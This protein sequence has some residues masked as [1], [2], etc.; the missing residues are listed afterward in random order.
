MAQMLRDTDST[1]RHLNM[2]RRH[3]R[4]CGYV[5]GTEQLITNLKSGVDVLLQKQAAANVAKEKREDAYDLMLLE[6]ANL[7]NSVKTLF[8]NCQQYDRDNAGAPVLYRIFTDG[9]FSTISEMNRTDEPDAVLQLAI[10]LESLGSEHPL[11]ALAATMREKAT[12]TRNA[13]ENHKQLVLA[14]ENAWTE[15]LVARAGLRQL[16]EENYLDARKRFGK[17]QAERLFPKMIRPS[18]KE[19]TTPDTPAAN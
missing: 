12:V 3:I 19:E 9:K 4:L 15:E 2:T 1:E 10:R 14:E 8:E 13:I 6:D 17:D 18:K 7:D 11:A 16:Y 5:K